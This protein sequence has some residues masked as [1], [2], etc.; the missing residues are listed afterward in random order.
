M[1]RMTGYSRVMPLAPRMLRDWRAMS[2]AALV[3]ASLPKLTWRGV[4][5]PAS[6]SEPRWRA[7]SWDWAWATYI[8]A[9]FSWVSW[10][11]PMGRSNW[12]R[13]LEYSMAD[14]RQ[15]RAAPTTPQRMP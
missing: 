10:K 6:L 2:R 8:Q 4:R 1:W 9:S 5:A 7:V 12:T 13:V 3:L 11:P 15:A 14:S